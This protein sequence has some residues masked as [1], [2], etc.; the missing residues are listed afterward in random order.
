MEKMISLI[1]TKELKT[2]YWNHELQN[3]S[4]PETK[5]I[6]DSDTFVILYRQG[7][8]KVLVHYVDH[9]VSVMFRESDLEIIG[10]RIESFQLFFTSLVEKKMVWKL[11]ENG[12]ELNNGDF[13]ISCNKQT[14]AK[15]AEKYIYDVAASRT[16]K[17][18]ILIPDYV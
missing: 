8:E 14:D 13:I 3:G 5:F 6:K 18:G 17:G 4:K 16:K 1:D 15:E 10:L 2:N 9:F 7:K 12:I 11:S